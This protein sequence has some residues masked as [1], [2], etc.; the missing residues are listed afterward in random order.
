M[1]TPSPWVRRWAPQWK[2]GT[3][4]LDVACGTG[5][6]ATWLASLGLQVTGID[7]DADA[8]AQLPAAVEALAAD[9]ENAPWPLPGRQFDVVL[10]THYLWR[11]L[12]PALLASVAPGGWYL[13]E[14]FADGQQHLGRPRNPDFLLKPGELLQV[15]QGLHTLAYEDGVVNGARLQR[16]AARRLGDAQPLLESAVLQ[17]F[18]P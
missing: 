15:T 16:V 18:Q 8:L 14:T 3:T 5:R 7:R 2:P 11:P 10:V 17:N 9:L 1:S 13:H 6:H 4:V 12:F